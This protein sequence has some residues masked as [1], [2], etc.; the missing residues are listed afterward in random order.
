MLT[1]VGLKSR[2][3]DA[4]WSR[5]SQEVQ[6]LTGVGLKSRGTDADWSRLKVK[7]YRR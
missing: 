4:D 2:G 5:L 6:T 3:T 7:R 1:G